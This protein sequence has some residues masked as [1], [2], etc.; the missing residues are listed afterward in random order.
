[1]EATV[2]TEGNLP[3]CHPKQNKH[4]ERNCCCSTGSGSDLQDLLDITQRFVP[5]KLFEEYC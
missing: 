3:E 5:S 2:M 4:P 1:M